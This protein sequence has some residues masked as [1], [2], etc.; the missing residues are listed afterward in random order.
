MAASKRVTDA[1]E[2]TEA[3]AS[4]ATEIIVEGQITGMPMITLPPGVTIRGGVL[5]FG[6]KGI[7]LT[8]NNTLDGVTVLTEPDEVAIGNDTSVP[9]LGTLT[10][11]D[12]RTVG[13]VLLT[14]EHAVRAGDLRIE[15]LRIDQ[16]DVRGRVDRPYGF[17][18]EALQGALTVWNLQSDPAVT[19]TAELLDIA[20]GTAGRPIRGSG[21]FVG[22]HSATGEGGVLRVSHL[23]TGEIHTD[24]GIPTGTPDLISGG[25][26]VIHGAVVERV[27]NA[28][29]VTT[30]GQNDMVLDN[31]GDVTT[32][33]ATQPITSHGPSGI[34]FVN[35]GA[36][37]RLDVR[38]PIATHGTGA[39]GFNLYDGTLREANFTDITTTGD[40]SVGVQIS[41]PLGTLTISGNLTTR[42][43]TGISLVKGVQ[44]RL[45]A[46]A[47]SIKPGAR[48]DRIAVGGSIE[49]AGD[50]VTAVEL[51]G[52]VGDFSVTG[53]IRASGKNSDAVHVAGEVP[54]LD[55]I[56]LT[57]ADGRPIVRS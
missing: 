34:G 48:I 49:S 44:T 38:A 8:S 2:L 29:P 53:G 4:G 28:G 15:G 47:L 16:A 26:F 32:W 55:A 45:S 36:L 27:T 56:M 35:F 13:Q 23:R 43:G 20:A 50:E 21:V 24:G 19:I 9:A 25:V 18:V 52:V 17:G 30:H 33:T 41:K 1:G 37:D 5:R 22:G 40:G 31:W 51:E 6:A 14:A 42:G 7:R 3:L 39:R 12:V 10:L 57:V 54:G 46:V 11:R